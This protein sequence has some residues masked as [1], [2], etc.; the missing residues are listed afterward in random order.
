MVVVRRQGEADIRVLRGF[1]PQL[2][3]TMTEM[4]KLGNKS[5]DTE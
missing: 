5:D 1:R 3:A 2:I 4:N